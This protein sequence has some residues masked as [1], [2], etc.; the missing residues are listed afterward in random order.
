[1]ADLDFFF[2]PVCPWAWLTSRWV[3]EVASQRPLEVDWKFI[4]LKIVNEDKSY[5]KD[6]PEGYTRGHEIGRELLR[7]AAAIR[8]TEGNEGVGRYYTELGTRYHNQR[9]RKELLP[10]DAI[11]GWLEREMGIDPGIAKAAFDHGHDAILREETEQALTR[12]GRD[13]GTP[14]LTL[15]PPNGPSFFGPVISRVPRGKEALDVWEGITAAARLPYFWELKRI[16][17]EPPSF[18]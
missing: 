11:P 12:A 3:V 15:E 2:D 5:E 9:R 8:E 4:C 17:T 16:R 6:F 18:D 1:M 7:V 13:L 14:I 10:D